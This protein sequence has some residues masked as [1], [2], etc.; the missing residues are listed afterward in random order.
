VEPPAPDVEGVLD[1]DARFRL[2]FERSADAI[3]LLDTGPNLFVDYNQATLDMLRCTRHELSAMHPSALSPPRQPDGQDSFVKANAMIALAIQHGS[4]RFEWVHRSP[5][6][7]DFPVEVVLT[8]LTLGASPMLMVVWRDIT[9]RKRDEA[10]LRQA[11]R[12]ESL[13]VMAGGIA[14][15]FNNVL[16]AIS[17]HLELLRRNLHDPARAGQHLDTIVG[18]VTRAASL[19]RKMLAYSGEGPRCT[20]VLDVGALTDELIE[21]LRATASGR[22][23]IRSARPRDPAWVEADRTQLQQVI[24][25]LFTN[26]LEALDEPGGSITVRVGRRTVDEHALAEEL[27]GQGMQPG[28]FV[29][30][31]VEDTGHGMTPEVQARIFDPF[32]STKAPGRGLGLSA[33]LGI[34]HGHGGGFRIA[35]AVGVG[36]SFE[37]LLPAAQPATPP[38]EDTAPAGDARGTGTVLLVDDDR[39]IRASLSP[40]LAALGFDVLEAAG[41]REAVALFHAHAASIRWVLMDLTM[42]DLDGHSALV[43]LRAIAPDVRVVMTSGWA[44]AEVLARFA[45]HPP[46][47]LLPKPFTL[48][49]LTAVLARIGVVDRG[50]R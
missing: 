47:A 37:V 50:R 25:N 2:M 15:D 19:T 48:A 10:A 28:P 42:P 39:G 45:D 11:Q 20:E 21:L 33:V 3:L 36:T 26:A 43:A 34:L 27:R 12:L 49:E 29:T 41:G 46:A 6:R 22:A 35:S 24:M 1:G 30:L 13:G 44:P 38:A 16:A 40:L 18:A 14:H 4:H 7:D 31:V 5:C 23:A 17:V 8:T 9:E 32:F